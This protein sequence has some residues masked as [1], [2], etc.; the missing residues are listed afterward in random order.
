MDGSWPGS[1]VQ[2]ILQARI[3][4]GV[5]MPSSRGSSRPRDRIWVSWV[6][7]IGRYVLYHQHH[8][9]I[10]QYK[11]KSFLSLKK[12][13]KTA[14]SSLFNQ[15]GSIS[16]MGIGNKTFFF[17]FWLVFKNVTLFQKKIWTNCRVRVP[18]FL[19]WMFHLSQT[20]CGLRGCRA[21]TGLR[22]ATGRSVLTLSALASASPPSCDPELWLPGSE[23]PPLRRR[24]SEKD[25]RDAELRGSI[26]H[27]KNVCSFAQSCPTLY[28][29]MDCSLPGSSVH[30]IFHARILE[31]VVISF[32]T[33][34]SQPRNWTCVPCISCSGRQIL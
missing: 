22:A 8:L 1:S 5:V 18:S 11:I 33:G 19:D 23:K 6:S 28:D 4:E 9:G 25:W 31:W 14:P 21:L 29:P 20:A 3:Q 32:S 26:I 13:K 30:G 17:F 12:K 16:V 7:C 34:Y 24:S 27:W 10:S 15:S 2:G